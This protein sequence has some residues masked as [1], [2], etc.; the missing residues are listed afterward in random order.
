[1]SRQKLQCAMEDG[2]NFSS[3]QLAAAK[4]KRVKSYHNKGGGANN[5]RGR[6][7]R[8][9]LGRDSPVSSAIGQY[10]I[11]IVEDE[12]KDVESRYIITGDERLVQDSSIA[13]PDMSDIDCSSS[14]MV[15]KALS[16]SSSISLTF[17]DF[18]FFILLS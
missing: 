7:G 18:R 3:K 2:K 10:S 13:V 4:Y 9:V 6:G 16:V 5:V 8:T 1:M 11:D 15:K 12:F 14:S 17:K